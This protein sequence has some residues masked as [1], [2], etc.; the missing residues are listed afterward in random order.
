MKAIITKIGDINL[1]IENPKNIKEKTTCEFIV[2]FNNEYEFDVMLDN[3]WTYGSLQKLILK[4]MDSCP[5]KV[6]DIYSTF[7]F[8]D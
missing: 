6:T 7:R 5:E 8:K 3:I 4:L 2:I 1:K